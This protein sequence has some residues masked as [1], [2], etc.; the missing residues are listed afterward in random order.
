MCVYIYIYTH[1]L[2]EHSHSRHV[3]V[4]VIRFMAIYTYMPMWAAFLVIWGL[5]WAKCL[6]NFVDL[7]AILLTSLLFLSTVFSNIL[8]TILSTFLS[9]NSVDKIILSTISSWQ[10]RGPPK[11]SYKHLMPFQIYL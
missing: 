3:D 7:G 2:F 5:F 8:S 11:L 4:N 6:N 10:D 1:R 9:T